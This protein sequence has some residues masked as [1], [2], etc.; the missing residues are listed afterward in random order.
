MS[1]NRIYYEA[2]HVDINYLSATLFPPLGAPN[3]LP[4]TILSLLFYFHHKFKLFMFLKNVNIIKDTFCRIGQIL[5]H[6]SHYAMKELL[7]ISW[8]TG[9]WLSRMLSIKFGN[10][11]GV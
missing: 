5:C 7:T 2:L 11:L 10:F 1:E 8:L 3:C 6:Y 9:R 4:E